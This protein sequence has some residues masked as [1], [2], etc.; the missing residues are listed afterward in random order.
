M[1]AAGYTTHVARGRALGVDRTT[2][3][4]VGSGDLP[5]SAAII[6]R[7]LHLLDRRFDDLFVVL[8][9]DGATCP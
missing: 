5:P 2:A 3:A 8:P 7:A 4:R 9:D 6:A 1:T